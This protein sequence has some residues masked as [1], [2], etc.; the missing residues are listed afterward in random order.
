MSTDMGSWITMAESQISLFQVSNSMAHL[1]SSRGIRRIIKKSRRHSACGLMFANKGC[2][3]QQ[4][5][6]PQDQ[7]NAKKK[8]KQAKLPVSC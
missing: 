1:V 8:P 4:T 7:L 3:I 6:R 5:I 2:Q